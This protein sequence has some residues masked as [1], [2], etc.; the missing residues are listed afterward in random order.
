MNVTIPTEVM[1]GIKM[2]EDQAI[3]ETIEERF[4]HL[5]KHEILD[6]ACWMTTNP[7]Y[8]F[9]AAVGA[10]MLSY[11]VGTM[12][13]ERIQT[14]MMQIQAVSALITASQAGLTVSNLPEVDPGHKPI[15][16]LRMWHAR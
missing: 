8:K 11:G 15:G 12:E 1:I 10:L 16:L 14:E 6:Q 4:T 3:G 7:D 13:F 2:L 9:R 5:I